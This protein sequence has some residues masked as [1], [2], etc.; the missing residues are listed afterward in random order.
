M[1]TSKDSIEMISDLSNKSYEAVKSLGEINL[2]L[3]ERT[4][5]RQMDALNVLMDGGLRNLKIVAE[6]TG[7]NDVV[8]GQVDLVREFSERM[9]VEGRE[10]VKLATD[11]RDEYRT[12]L[13]QGVQ[14]F[15]EKMNKMRPTA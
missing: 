3:M 13:E 7:P 14:V 5:A 8:R 1:I 12:W 2:R 10:T 4:L 15:S 9:L 11:T 6:A